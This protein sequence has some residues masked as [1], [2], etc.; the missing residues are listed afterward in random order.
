MARAPDGRLTRLARLARFLGR[1]LLSLCDRCQ[2]CSGLLPDQGHPHPIC[3]GC[4]VGL[5]PRL[6]GYCPRCGGLGLEAAATPVVCPDCL[7][8][9]R[10]WDGFAFHGPYEGLLREMVLAFKFHGGIAKGRLLAGL[11]ADAYLRAAAR[12]GEGA[13]DPAG[14]DILVPVPLHPRRLA[15]RGFNQSLELSR[16]LASRLGRPIVSSALAR[17]RDTTP[18]SSLPGAKR[19][20]NIAGAFAAVPAIVGGRAVLLVDDVMTTGATVDTAAR[21]LRFAGAARV[22]VVVVAR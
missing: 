6:G 10:S 16:G 5:A 2:A 20:A 12:Q 4:A 17:I 13:M 1:R 15:W 14:P 9:G 19:Q 11:L 22:D 18:Q 21:A 3:P 7:R 8:Q